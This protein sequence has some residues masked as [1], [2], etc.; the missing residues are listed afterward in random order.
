MADDS[1]RVSNCRELV[2]ENVSPLY[3]PKAL[4]VLLHMHVPMTENLVQM[5]CD[6]TQWLVPS[7]SSVQLLGVKLIS[8][9]L[10]SFTIDRYVK[11]ANFSQSTGGY[12]A[13]CQSVN[14]FYVKHR[15]P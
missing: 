11:D 12:L 2:P 10:V 1:F 13:D 9:A 5:F 6:R 15:V 14:E 4:F 3:A 7:Q 8:N